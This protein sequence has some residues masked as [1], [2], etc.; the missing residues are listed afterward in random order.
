MLVPLSRNVEANKERRG[1]STSP[2]GTPEHLPVATVSHEAGIKSTLCLTQEG[3]CRPPIPTNICMS[4][5]LTA[6]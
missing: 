5:L 2:S 4:I 1:R 6:D 3:A